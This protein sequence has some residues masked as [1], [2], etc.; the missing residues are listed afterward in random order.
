MLNEGWQQQ[1]GGGEEVNYRKWITQFPSSPGTIFLYIRKRRGRKSFRF[2]GNWW[3]LFSRLSN[4]MSN[5][6]N[7]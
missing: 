7:V 2:S 3:K 5:Y 6:I 4:E 1:T